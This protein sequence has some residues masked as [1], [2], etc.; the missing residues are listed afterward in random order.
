MTVMPAVMAVVDHLY[1]APA[2]LVNVALPPAQMVLAP[3]I[4]AGGAEYTITD[5]A[6]DAVQPA[7]LVTVTRYVVLVVGDT[8][9]AAVVA[10]FDQ[11]YVPPP[12]AVRVVLEPLHIGDVPVMLATGSAL[13]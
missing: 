10:P 11:E 2:E 1:E 3:V 4:V 8:V 6:A 12:E 7:A 13:T 5:L 9:V